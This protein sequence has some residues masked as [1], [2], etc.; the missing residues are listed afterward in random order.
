MVSCC[1]GINIYY[2]HEKKGLCKN[3]DISLVGFN[4]S[5]YYQNP[6]ANIKSLNCMMYGLPG[7]L[8]HWYNIKYSFRFISGMGEIGKRRL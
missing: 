5:L 2:S 7:Q 6:E 1:I 3:Y 4:T 8:F